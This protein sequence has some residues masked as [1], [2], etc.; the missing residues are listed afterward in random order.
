MKAFLSRKKLKPLWVFKSPEK[1]R[2]WKIFPTRFDKILCELRDLE[3]RIVKFVCLSIK[4]GNPVW[5]N[6]NLDQTWWVQI[7]DSDEDLFFLCEFRRPDLPIQGKIYAVS[8]ETGEILWENNDHNFL[9]ALNGKVYTVKNLTE[10]RFFFEIDSRTG[11]VVQEFGQN[12]DFINELKEMK[13][14][15]MNFIET[16]QPFDEYHPDYNYLA[17]NIKPLTENADSRFPPEILIKKNF[18]IINY[19]I[20]N[21]PKLPL[22]TESFSNILKIINLDKNELIY[23]DVLYSDLSFFIQD[24]FFCKDDFVFYVKNQSELIAIKLPL[25]HEDNHG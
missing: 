24:A 6:P 4:N 1:F 20:L 13:S 22:E 5:E 18:A 3:K 17:E 19:H 14:E 10:Q 21:K 7:S 9:F 11:E 2:I 15:S 8:S 25:N 16:S 12:S 23:E